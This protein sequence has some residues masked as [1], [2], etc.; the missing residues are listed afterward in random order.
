MDICAC[1]FRS[2]APGSAADLVKS[3]SSELDAILGSVR[4][5]VDKI[6]AVGDA[7]RAERRSLG[8]TWGKLQAK[9]RE[10]EKEQ[11]GWDAFD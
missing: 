6:K 5:V 10:M 1:A 7:K 11:V 2:R 4:T 9:R 8:H 3:C